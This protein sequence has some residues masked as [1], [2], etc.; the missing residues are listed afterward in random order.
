M[1]DSFEAAPSPLLRIQLQQPCSVDGQPASHQSVWFLARLWLA[2]QCR[3][4]GVEAGGLAQRFNRAADV[5][6]LVSRC[7]A[8]FSRWGI[9]VGWGSD[10]AIDPRLLPLRGRSRGPFWLTPPSAA[11]LTFWLGEAVLDLAGVQSALG[12]A[13]SV[14]TAATTRHPLDEAMQRLDFWYHLALGKRDFLDGRLADDAGQGERKRSGALAHFGQAQDYAGDGFQQ[15]LALL[16][17]GMTW[18]RLGNLEQ[19]VRSLQALER[20]SGQHGSPTLTAMTHLLYGWHAYAT[21]DEATVRR[22][23][24]NLQSNEETRNAVRYNPRVRCEFHNLN[25]LLHKAEATHESRE[26]AERRRHALIAVGDFSKALQAAFEA[27]SLDAAQH[28]AANLGLVL[29][30]FWK[31]GLLDPER[32]YDLLS[33]QQQAIRWIGMSEWICD[34]FGLGSNSIWNTIFLLRVVRGAC[35]AGDSPEL[36]AFRCQ[37]PMPVATFLEAARPF[38]ATFSHAKGFGSWPQLTALLLQEHD[39]GRVRYEPLQLAN[40]LFEHL[41]FGLQSGEDGDGDA[42]AVRLG[43]LLPELA[44]RDHQF[45]RSILAGLPLATQHLACTADMA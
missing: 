27:D 18:R 44:G 10:N 41:W 14:G 28:V 5:R 24:V 6:M 12:L 33:I 22:E 4:Y 1:A 40:L 20:L 39:E 29:W 17:A 38:H 9:V 19:S 35:W 34:R 37:Q 45:F 30:L 23:L 13:P 7:F 36:S 16:N 25:A 42:T 26:L 3:E 15:G 11:R 31:E 43:R 32:H 8:D 21:R 2:L